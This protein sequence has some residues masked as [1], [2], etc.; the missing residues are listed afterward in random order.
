MG[1]DAIEIGSE[2]YTCELSADAA[3]AVEVAPGSVLRAHCRSACDRII[4]PEGDRAPAANPGTG[5]IAVTG[6]E[7]AQALRLEIIDIEPDSPGHVSAGWKG[8]GGMQAVEIVGRKAVFHGIEIPIAPSIG[9]LGVAPAEGSWDTMIA[10]PFGGNIDTNDVAAGATVY[11]PVF[12]PGG[13]LILGDVHAVMGDGEIGGQGLECAATVTM[14][15]DLEPEPISDHVY[16]VRDGRL[17]VVAAAERIEDA[18]RDASVEMMRIIEAAGVLDE[19]NAMKLL[20]LAGETLF[21]QHC[22]RTKTVRVSL[23]LKHVPALQAKLLPRLSR[24]S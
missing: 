4:G 18:V 3:A 11:L 9:T 1:M 2:R 13:L 7:P 6:A 23:P 22:C 15:V 5:P 8:E 17:M 14:R 24:R 21:G 16:L 12:Q 20:G 10:G 19:F